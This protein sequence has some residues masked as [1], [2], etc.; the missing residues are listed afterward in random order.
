MNKRTLIALVLCGIAASWMLEPVRA[1][2]GNGKGGGGGGSTPT[3]TQVEIAD[4]YFM[5][6]E[7]KLAR[8]VYRALF[9]MWGNQVFYNISL[10][11]QKHADAVLGL[12]EKYGLKDP[13]SLDEGVFNDP[14]LQKLYDDLM[15]MGDDG[16]LEALEVGVLIEVTD[17]TDIEEC[18]K[19][20]DKADILNVCGNLL[21]GS[22]NHLDAFLRNVE[23]Y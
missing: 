18:M 20:T 10:S 15:A 6:E 9:D 19:H 14:Y 3:L 17:I 11:E 8:D 23:A 5:R 21:D 4:L 7:E 22:F 2:K 12:I 1:G 13:A 16:E